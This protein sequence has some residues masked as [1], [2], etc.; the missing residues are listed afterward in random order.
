[1]IL[2]VFFPVPFT[3]TVPLIGG[4]QPVYGRLP[5]LLQLGIIF[6]VAPFILLSATK[7]TV[8]SARVKRK[9]QTAVCAICAV[10]G[11]LATGF[12]TL[13]VF[14][15]GAGPRA[16]AFAAVGLAIAALIVFAGDIWRMSNKKNAAYG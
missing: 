15:L 11:L 10:L 9:T 8:R 2:L 3:D 7:L 5:E 4:L 1:M 14:A 16:F 6:T 13:A 12:A